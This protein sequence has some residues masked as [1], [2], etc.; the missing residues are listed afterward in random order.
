MRRTKLDGWQYEHY[1]AEYLKKIGFTDVQVTQGSGDQGV[2]IIA[3]NGA[4]K[5][6]IQCKYYSGAVSNKAVQEVFTGMHYYGCDIALIITNSYFTKSA[7]ELAQRTNVVLWS[8]ISPKVLNDK[9]Q[10]Y[11]VKSRL[12][13][14]Y[15][16]D[17]IKS[18]VPT[19]DNKEIRDLIGYDVHTNDNK[20]IRILIGYDTEGNSFLCNLNYQIHLLVGGTTGS[21]KTALLHSVIMSIINN[22]QPENVRIII[23]DPKGIEFNDYNGV[24]HLLIP[25]VNNSSKVL[26]CLSWIVNEIND[27]YRKFKDAYVKTIEEY[28]NK[29]SSNKMPH[30]VFVIDEWGIISRERGHEGNALLETILQNSRPAGIHVI[31]AT[32]HASSNVITHNMLSSIPARAVFSV[33]SG[34]ESSWM[35]GRKGAENLY[36]PGKLLFCDFGTV[37]PLQLT[38]YDIDE[39]MISRVTSFFRVDEI[40]KEERNTFHTIIDKPEESDNNTTDLDEF[41]EAA[42]RFIVEK[43]KATIGMLQRMFK[44]GFNRAARLL[45]QLYEEGI[46]GPEEGTRPRKV[47]VSPEELDRYF[48]EEGSAQSHYIFRSKNPDLHGKPEHNLLDDKLTC[49]VGNNEEKMNE[50]SYSDESNSYHSI[51][52]KINE[53]LLDRSE[54]RESDNR[55]NHNANEMLLDRSEKKE[56]DKCKNHKNILVI[57]FSATGTTF[58]MAEELTTAIDAD[59]FE[60]EPV[61]DYTEKD[62]RWSNPLSRCNREKLLKKDVELKYYVEGFEKY[63]YVY[64]GFPIWYGCAPNIV[65]SFCKIHDWRGKKVGVFATSGGSGI[66][67]TIEKLLPYIKGAHVIGGRVFDKADEAINWAKALIQ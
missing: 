9:T 41:F 8:N 51:L 48:E 60:I 10:N 13:Y 15:Y 21:G 29:Y 57:Y 18:I 40:N 27:R 37:E 58:K 59:I 49:S 66:G 52:D 34:S 61:N 44:I 25:V 4:D 36:E 30:I 7:Q 55:K 33:T 64:L 54:K 50:Q 45:D 31:L 17:A 38:T 3:N 16:K 1:C 47:M 12:K 20:E 26:S 42:A 62:L 28:N 56:L 24:P 35:L 65:N 63:D 2:D 6:A 53:M 39:T 14:D 67:K 19:I 22:N 43:D 23:A 46:I 11:E 32:S 5:Y